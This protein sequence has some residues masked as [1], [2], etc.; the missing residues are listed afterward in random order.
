MNQTDISR[1]WSVEEG[2][3]VI[4]L[5]QSF[6]RTCALCGATGVCDSADGATRGRGSGADDAVGWA[7]RASN[8][9]IDSDCFALCLSVKSDNFFS[10]TSCSAIVHNAVRNSFACISLIRL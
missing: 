5:D 2:G 6:I 7:S 1:R 8:A 9:A 10:M 4:F 3:S